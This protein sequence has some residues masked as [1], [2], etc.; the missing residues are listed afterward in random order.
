MWSFHPKISC[1]T[2]FLSAV[3]QK[4]SGFSDNFCK[5]N[6][7]EWLQ[8]HGQHRSP[9]QVCNRIFPGLAQRPWKLKDGNG[10]D[11]G[12]RNTW[13][14]GVQASGDCLTSYLSSWILFSGFT[15]RGGASG[16]ADAGVKSTWTRGV[17]A[18]GDCTHNIYHLKTRF[19]IYI[20]KWCLGE[21]WYRSQEYLE[22]RSAGFM[23]LYT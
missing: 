16:R 22:K 3:F 1:T 10:G 5:W 18:S 13:R 15:S 8:S 11:T 21:S 17:Q 7:Y 20:K 4:S 19:Q 14:R 23:W 9:A 6:I 2:R 12:V